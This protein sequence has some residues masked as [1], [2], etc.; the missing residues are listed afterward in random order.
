VANVK[1]A[2]MDA[3]EVLK[4]LNSDPEKGLT[5]KEVEKRYKRFGPNKLLDY[6]RISS[7]KI[8]LSQFQDPIVLILIGATLIS[9]MLGEY[10]DAL[11]IFAIV[12]LNAILGLVQEYKAE[13]SI[14][15]LKKITS[16][17][18]YVIRNGMEQEV[19]AE[20]IVPGDIVFL[21]AGDRVPADI[22]LLKT[23][24]LEA[25]ESALTGES[26]PVRKEAQNICQ[27]N[28]Q[29]ADQ[30]NTVFMGT[31]I[32]RGRGRGVVVSTGMDTEVGQIAGLIQEADE[33]ETPLQRRLAGVGKKLVALCLVICAFVTVV[34]I[35]QG[36]PAYRMFLIGVSLAVA[37]IPE[38]MPAIVTVALA[39]G[40]QRM[41][42]RH[43]LIRKLPVVET[44]GCA[45]VICSD[46][47]G[48]LTKNEMTVR[49]LWVDGRTVGVSGEGYSPKGK[50]IAGGKEI[51]VKDVPGLSLFL[52]I[53]ALCNNSM[54]VKNG[55]GISGFFRR[56][57][58]PTWNIKGDPTEGAL[59]VAA[60]K[61]GIWRERIE[62]EEERIGEIPFDSERKR[63]SVIYR[64]GPEKFLY[65]KG[66]PDVILERSS[67][68]L[69][70]GKITPL[71]E[72]HKQDILSQNKG[73]A[74]RA[75]RVLALAYRNISKNMDQYDETL[76]TGLIF[77]GL[78]A[79]IDPPRPEIKR[80]IKKCVE[81][82]IRVIMITGDHPATAAAVAREI[83]LGGLENGVITG[84]QIDALPEKEF[85]KVVDRVSVY[86]RVSP[87][88][89]LRIVR[90]LKA[91]GNIV[92]MTG[93]GVNDAPAVKEADVG[94]AM[95]ITGTDVT[96][97]ASAMIL[98]DDNFATI[99]AAVEEGRIIY[100]NIRKFI[101][102]MLAC[103]IGEV[104]TMFL[105]IILG[106]PLPLAPIQILFVNLVTDGLPAMALALEKGEQ[107]IMS[108]PPR[109]PDESIFSGG[110]SRKIISRGLFI[111]VGTL[112]VFVLGLV[113]GEGELET[114]RTMSFCSLVFF[115][116]FYVFE[117]RSDRSSLLRVGLLSNPYL[118][119]AVLSSILMQLAVVYVPILQVIFK[120]VSL[121]NFHWA[122]VLSVT[123][124]A[125]LLNV[126]YQLTVLPMARRI[127]SVRV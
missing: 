49:E 16:P 57:R 119:A 110:L 102:Y 26:R 23:L 38:G 43:A 44:L 40:V 94:I 109:H 48:T 34:G 82:G 99:V 71:T 86:A 14:E 1:W 124:A 62:E 35:A 91:K 29:L 2:C 17:T 83:G 39:I 97:E 21:K 106:L 42:R 53:A 105:A 126:L 75:M 9:G 112:L 115:Q 66:A 114:A 55:L 84:S 85:S 6:K 4:I 122:V 125:T 74:G 31:L 103:N 18:A 81:A 45:T 69:S 33:T 70:G 60:A 89:K 52:K 37:A 111:G 123:G 13:E 101:R 64:S 78:A 11:T 46:K 54:L 15:A 90:C 100:D 50:F 76:E 7:L 10:A 3:N 73:M 107:D 98:A 77:L 79:M 8:F 58:G 41:L 19:P 108:R 5:N 72:E 88:H 30:R 22:R 117:C 87:K 121:N 93:D 95:G 28:T 12:V 120:T 47:T 96:K 36:N 80:A 59:L 20:E 104:I 113:L 24:H 56:S 118:I 116:L 127:I 27:G 68:C 67:Y 25:E 61:A 51:S 92:A 32:T 65:V 63:M